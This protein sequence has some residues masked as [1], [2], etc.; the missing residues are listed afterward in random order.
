M[1]PYRDFLSGRIK[2]LADEISTG[3]ESG[4]ADFPE[5]ANMSREIY[6][7]CKVIGHLDNEGAFTPPP[8]CQIKVIT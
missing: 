1:Q 5:I 2:T 6:S 4:D 3:V 7:Y 8:P